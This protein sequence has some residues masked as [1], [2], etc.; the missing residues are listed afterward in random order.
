MIFSYQM[1]VTRIPVSAIMDIAVDTKYYLW[2]NDV[3]AVFEG[4]LHRGPAPGAGYYDEI[5]IS[6]YLKVGINFIKILVW[7]FGNQGRNSIDST[8]AYLICD[9][10]IDGEITGSDQSW[11]VKRHLGYI[12]TKEPYPSYL[13]GG[14]NIGYDETVDIDEVPFEHATVHE[15]VSC[16]ELYKRPVPLF[17]Q[18]GLQNFKDII[19]N[20]KESCNEYIGILP[21]GCQV[22]PAFMIDSPH[23]KEMIDIRTDRYEVHGGPGDEHHTYRGHRVEY[24][25]KKGVAQFEA[26]N[27][28]FGEK[29]IF[30]FPK[31]VKVEYIKY[32]ESGYDTTLAGSFTC[33]DEVLNNLYSKS[34]RTLYACMRDNYMDCPDRERGQWIGD[35]SS[36]IPQV[37]Y[38]LGRSA[39][40]LTEKAI[41]DFINFRE[42]HILKGNVPGSH[43][44]ELVTQSLNAISPIGMIMTY[45]KNTGNAAV[46]EK[47]Y[48]PSLE[49]L[50]LWQFDENN[51]LVS[52]KG[53][54][55]WCDH[56]EHVDRE[57]IEVCWVYYALKS[58]YEMAEIL[59][60]DSD[61]TLL[62]QRMNHI[63]SYFHQKYFKG[64]GYRTG[65][66]LDDRANGIALLSGLVEPEA[67]DKVVH[68]LESVYRATPY[69]EYY[70]LEALFQN[71]EHEA[72]MK[73]MLNRYHAMAE[74]LNS[75]M[76]EDFHVF[77]T[78]NHAWSGGPLTI[79]IKYILGLQMKDLAYRE[80]TVS[81]KLLHVNHIK[82]VIPT[83][84][85]DISIEVDQETVKVTHPPECI[86]RGTI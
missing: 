12:N 74:S 71:K 79:L 35:V 75:T 65:E 53:N 36:Q 17:R 44:G 23:D 24:L 77:G 60:I 27:W 64:D 1:S 29:V 86:Y 66:F 41:N 55:Y 80:F 85:G 76:W 52:R 8:Q 3:L 37:F 20:E 67:Y 56:G 33:D 6:G 28:F 25:T 2:I 82:A 83:I 50:M 39:D 15:N 72:G 34:Q 7:Y 49:Y 63:R 32:R 4:G 30:T 42:N 9:I 57:I 22:T 38:S 70:I 54:W 21:Y 13:Y 59:H 62:I 31:D 14:Y 40:L 58:V 45:Y 84:Y 69:F 73:R 78:Y 5:D 48:Q 81:P 43:S 61:K 68:V 47:A 46:I 19:I 18:G 11:M 26:F 10:S 16:G 51:Q